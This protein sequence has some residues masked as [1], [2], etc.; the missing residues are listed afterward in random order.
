[1]SV[2]PNDVA[3]EIARKWAGRIHDEHDKGAEHYFALRDILWAA[4]AT[5]GMDRYTAG[6]ESRELEFQQMKIKAFTEG[7]RTANSLIPEVG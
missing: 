2:D 3:F 4:I 7:I 1:M 5:Y 6:R